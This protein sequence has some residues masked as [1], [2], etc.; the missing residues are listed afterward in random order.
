MKSPKRGS[1]KQPDLPDWDPVK[2]ADKCYE[3]IVKQATKD[4]MQFIQDLFPEET[5]LC[6]TYVDEA[7]ELKLCFWIFLRILQSQESSMK[8][9]Y[10][11]MGTKSSISYYAPSPENSESL[12]CVYA[13]MPD[14]TTSALSETAKG[15]SPAGTTVHCPRLRP[16]CDFAEWD[17]NGFSHG[18]FRNR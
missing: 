7:H 15:A 17:A 1:D 5:P 18:Y 3:N 14:V 13:A 2:L 10:V 8:M 16:T 9:W 12:P 11:F 6:L 4:L